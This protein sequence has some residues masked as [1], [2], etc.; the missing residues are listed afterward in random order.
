MDYVHKPC[1]VIGVLYLPRQRLSSFLLFY[2]EDVSI[3]EWSSTVPRRV[4]YYATRY[5][6]L[7]FYYVRSNIVSMTRLRVTDV[8]RG[9]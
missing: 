4:A 7:A 6:T 3:D 8:I 2:T 1:S 9:K 5:A